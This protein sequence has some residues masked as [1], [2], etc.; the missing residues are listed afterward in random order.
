ML[1]TLDEQR[2]AGG[3]STDHCT[4]GFQRGFLQRF[5]A[6]VALTSIYSLSDGVLRW[7]TCVADYSDCVEVSGSHIGLAFNRHAYGAIAEALAR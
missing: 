3:C 7:Q 2:R 5:P 6:E 1:V 4:C